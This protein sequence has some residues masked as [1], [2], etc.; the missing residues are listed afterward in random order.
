MFLLSSNA[1]EIALMAG[2]MV[3]GLPIPLTAVQILYVNLATDGLP[4]LALAVD[5][6][7]A[8]HGG[9]GH[10]LA[11]RCGSHTARRVLVGAGER[12][13]VQLGAR[14]PIRCPRGDDD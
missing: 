13:A 5:P 7:P 1:G 9:I 3:L 8:P 11:A 6:P 14:D 12:G 2:A 10:L 4:A